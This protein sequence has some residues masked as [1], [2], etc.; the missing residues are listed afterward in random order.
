[1]QTKDK[2]NYFGAVNIYVDQ[3][4]VT[5]N[6]IKI[7]NATNPSGARN[8]SKSLHA[9]R[10][11]VQ[12]LSILRSRWSNC[13]ENPNRAN[14]D[15]GL[16]RVNI[17]SPKLWNNGSVQALAV[18]GMKKNNNNKKNHQEQKQI[19]NFYHNSEQLVMAGSQNKKINVIIVKSS[20]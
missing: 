18:Q 14:H 4:A 2:W 7:L 11:F 12:S 17:D 8:D 16:S 6:A 5:I 20:S 1:M 13:T 9:S 15:D 10:Q 19:I 3:S